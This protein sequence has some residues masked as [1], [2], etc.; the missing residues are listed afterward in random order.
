MVFKIVSQ[1]LRAYEGSGQK[2]GS[3]SLVQ[4]GYR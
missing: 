3:T 1:L 4:G 2:K